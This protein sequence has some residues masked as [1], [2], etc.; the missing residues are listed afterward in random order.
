MAPPAH[1]DA[2][3][4]ARSLEAAASRKDAAPSALR[5]NLA[6]ITVLIARDLKRFFR[7]RSR[8][9]GA[10]VQPLIFWL[11]IGSGLGRSFHLGGADRRCANGCQP[12][13][14]PNQAKRASVEYVGP[15]F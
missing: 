9:I 10:M 6:A 1:P 7:Q 8:V 3:A 5:L 4:T 13:T 15:S 14:T 12:S 11:V 2:P